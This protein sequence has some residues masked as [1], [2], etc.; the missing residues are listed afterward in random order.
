MNLFNI[1]NEI[2]NFTEKIDI[3]ELYERKRISD[4]QKLETF[5]KLLNRVHIRIKLTSKKTN[6]KFCW[7]I[8]PEIILGIS[9]FDHAGCIGFLMEKLKS[10]GFNVF[11]YHPNSLFITWE[12]WVPSYVRS[13]LKKKTGLEVNEFG[14]KIETIEQPLQIT[15]VMKEDKRKKFTP[16]DS[17]KPKGIYNDI[18]NKLS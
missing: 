9:Q 5:N 18:L 3:D 14:Q 7:F 6:D 15:N 11:Y 12:H 4:V 16:I 1:D 13:E 2:D 17:Y 10:N 8:V